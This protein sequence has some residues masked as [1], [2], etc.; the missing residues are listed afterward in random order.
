MDDPAL[1]KNALHGEALMTPR[2]VAERLRVSMKTLIL[3]VH[4]GDLPYVNVGRGKKHQRRMFIAQ[5]V[6]EFIERRKRRET[7][8]GFTPKARAL[9][10]ARVLSSRDAQVLEQRAKLLSDIAKRR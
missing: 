6:E 2:E 4:D 7:P 3:L 10:K 1:R 8:I 9:S 5:D